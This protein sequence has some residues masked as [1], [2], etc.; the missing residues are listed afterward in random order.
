MKEHIDYDSDIFLERSM[1]M[2]FYM[3]FQ[4][5]KLIHKKNRRRSLRQFKAY[6]WVALSF[7][8]LGAVLSALFTAIDLVLYA[9]ISFGVLIISLISIIVIKFNPKELRREI[10]EEIKPAANKNMNDLIELLTSDDFQINID[11]QEEIDKLI[12][13]A[14]T[15][16][17]K[18]DYS[19]ELKKIIKLF[20][21]NLVLPLFGI[22]VAVLLKDLDIKA[23]INR[24]VIIIL[25][26]ALGLIAI[27]AL[28]SDLY[29]ILNSEKKK[30]EHFIQDM[31]EL[32]VF[33]NMIN[34]Q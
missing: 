21:D 33:H 24:A 27:F 14:K 26:G 19:S 15:E 9:Y 34:K 11:N 5:Y 18:Y 8:V 13:Y 31:E 10:S 25:L 6:E 32:I 1:K 16:L 28:T 30:L 29:A 20:G 12:Q 4:K 2:Y 22:V 17:E 3:L 7:L 23:T